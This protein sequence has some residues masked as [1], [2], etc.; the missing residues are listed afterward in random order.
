MRFLHLSPTLVLVIL[1]S[2]CPGSAGDAP[3][4]V[5]VLPDSTT[6]G[7][8]TPGPDS[9]PVNEEI[10]APGVTLTGVVLYQGPRRPLMQD[11][12]PATSSVPIIGGRDAL[13]RI[14]Y[15][16]DV[17]A[18]GQTVTARLTLEGV[19]QETPHT[20][21]TSSTEDDR[22]STVEF[23]IAGADLPDDEFSF[24]V[25]LL[26][27]G[28]PSLDHPPARY[29]T[30]GSETVIVDG[31]ASTLRITL[32]PF[33]YHADGSGRLP[34]LSAL[35]LAE[36]RDHLL[37]LYPVSEVQLTVR[38]AVPWYES[39]QPSG[40][41]WQ[42][43][44]LEV[45]SLR[46]SDGAGDDE[47]Y[48]GI[49][50]PANTLAQFC[51]TGCITGVHMVNDTPP[52]TGEVSLR[53]A[54]G[55][56]FPELAT[57]SLAHELA[58]AHGLMHANCGAGLDPSSVDPAYPHAGGL[59]GVWSWDPIHDLLAAPEAHPDLM[60]V[61]PDPWISDYHYERLHLRTLHVNLP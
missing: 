50:D 41:G 3:A 33:A 29:P 38:A 60:G 5:A 31:P 61:C 47:Y 8:A 39:I 37:Q 32:V 6:T 30:T 51:A 17:A 46:A 36:M 44:R 34:D 21:V 48:Y 52:D 7:D 53:L 58:H 49:F 16:V 54:V 24:G 14:F 23:L 19:V 35:R 26:Q 20:L 25:E 13:L 43:V 1:L 42:P 11:G 22:S 10:G 57:E 15:D 12:L 2:A 45:Y 9:G 18:V 40:T 27:L 4:D 55:L 59:M 56:G 28:D